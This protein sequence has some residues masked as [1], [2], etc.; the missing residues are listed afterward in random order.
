ML[1]SR[2]SSHSVGWRQHQED[3]PF[4]DRSRG[5]QD[6]PCPAPLRQPVCLSC[7]GEWK[8]SPDWDDQLT[9]DDCLR[10]RRETLR[11]GMRLDGA[12]HEAPLLGAGGLAENATDRA[13]S[14]HSRS[15]LA[16]VSPPTVSAMESSSGI[17]STMAGSSRA[18]TLST[19]A[20]P[21]L[22]PDPSGLRQSPVP[23]A[24]WP[25]GPPTGRRCRV[26]PSQG[27]GRSSAAAP[28][29]RSAAR[30]LAPRQGEQRVL[31]VEFRRQESQASNGQ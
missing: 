31:Q 19:R 6:L 17:R 12:N 10:K 5:E 4:S 25:H 28:P 22:A 3:S 21:L 30:R 18:T 26:R 13:A 14:P 1:L 11:V 8:T 2:F 29:P 16:T 24:S 27:A 7:I 9:G 15:S 20:S 23:P